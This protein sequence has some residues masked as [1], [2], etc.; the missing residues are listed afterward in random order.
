MRPRYI[1]MREMTIADKLMQA[2]WREASGREDGKWRVCRQFIWPVVHPE[3][4]DTYLE[5][6]RGPNGNIR[7]FKTW[8]AAAKAAKRLNAKD[9]TQFPIGTE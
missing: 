9:Y 3:N 7:L 6:A 4:G 1:D 8:K 2:R 5:E